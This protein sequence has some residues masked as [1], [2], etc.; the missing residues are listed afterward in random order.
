MTEHVSKAYLIAL[1][2]MKRVGPKDI[3]RKAM[4]AGEDLSFEGSTSDAELRAHLLS[5]HPDDE[6]RINLHLQLATWDTARIDDAEWAENTVPNTDERRDVILRGL[7]VDDETGAL[8]HHMFPVVHSGETIVI[9]DKW[10]PWYTAEVQQKRNFYWEHYQNYLVKQR[11]WDPNAVAKLDDATTHVVERLTNP[12]NKNPYQAKGLVVGYVQSGKTANFTGV[13][14]K[15]IDAGY[16]LVI[17]LTGTTNLLREQTQRRVDMELVGEENILRGVDITNPEALGDV[18]YQQD[19]DWAKGKFVKHGHR[20]STVG[21]P[22]IH[23]MTT[24]RADYRRPQSSSRHRRPGLRT[25]RPH[26]AP[27]TSRQPLHKRRP[28]RRG[29][30]E[31]VRA[32]EVRQGPCRDHRGTARDPGLDHR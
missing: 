30:E 20:P 19:E 24:R 23:R 25:S 2:A 10:D 7:K 1:D 4:I 27:D 12:V 28:A 13:I 11:S 18:D 3:H 14:A 5:A 21:R 17:V 8:F 32:Q 16:R 15:A 26:K 31:P 29:E 9:A 6:L 22:D